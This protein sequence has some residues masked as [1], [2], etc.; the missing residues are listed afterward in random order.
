MSSTRRR[1][2]SEPGLL[3][4]RMCKTFLPPAT[5]LPNMSL[6]EFTQHIGAASYELIAR[7]KEHANEVPIKVA[8]APGPSLAAVLVCERKKYDAALL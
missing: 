5:P 3:N 8:P 1:K 4:V 6:A 7:R 2:G